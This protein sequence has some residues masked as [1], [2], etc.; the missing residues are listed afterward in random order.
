VREN[1]LRFADE[2]SKRALEGLADAA[3]VLSPEQRVQLAQ[4]MEEHR[5]RWHGDRH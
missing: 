2:A 1:E 5:K 3:E 4:Q